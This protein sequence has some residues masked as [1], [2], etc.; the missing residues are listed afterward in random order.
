MRCLLA[1]LFCAGA[2]A[3]LTGVPPCTRTYHRVATPV[4]MDESVGM[5][6]FGVG[7]FG[8]ALGAGS[9]F[10]YVA[11]K[12][13]RTEKLEDLGAEARSRMAFYLGRNQF[14]SRISRQ[15]QDLGDRLLRRRRNG[16]RD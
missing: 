12:A 16:W 9:R 11:N 13:E 15:H 8:G 10:I 3:L 4:M 5:L 1:A 2:D 6:T 7:M 14:L